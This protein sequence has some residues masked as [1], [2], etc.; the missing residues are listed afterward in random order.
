MVRARLCRHVPQFYLC[1]AVPSREPGRG[2]NGHA[3]QYFNPVMNVR[4][5]VR[6]N[7]TIPVLPSTDFDR[8]CRFYA[9]LGF[10]DLNI[11]P[12]YLLLERDGQEIHFFLEQGDPA[13]GHGHSHFSAYI[14]ASGLD[15]LHVSIQSAGLAVELPSVRPW[16][17]KEMEI[18]DPDGSLLRFGEALEEA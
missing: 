17:Q 15:E 18:I 9:M 5:A 8:T 12:D 3:V 16:G 10:R 14:R 4:W 2:Q 11:Y 6:I 1:V 7:Q 13:H